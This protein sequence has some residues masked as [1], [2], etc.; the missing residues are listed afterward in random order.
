MTVENL[1]TK[2]ILLLP[3]IAS[4]VVS[5]ILVALTETAQISPAEYGQSPSGFAAAFVLALGGSL[6]VLWVLPLLMLAA[7]ALLIGRSHFPTRWPIIVPLGIAVMV[8]GVL[9]SYAKLV[10]YRPFAWYPPFMAFYAGVAI[11]L[12]A[13][14]ATF[15][16]SDRTAG[17]SRIVG[18]LARRVLPPL[19]LSIFAGLHVL[20]YQLYYDRYP[21]LHTSILMV[22]F[23]I[24]QAGLFSLFHLAPTIPRFKVPFRVALAV[25]S[26]LV[27]A[28]P[29]LCAIPSLNVFSPG[30]LRFTVVGQEISRNAWEA[31]NPGNKLGGGVRDPKGVEHFEKLSHMPPLPEDLDLLD[32]NILLV[33]IEAFRADESFMGSPARNLTP[34]LRAYAEEGAHWFPKAI[35]G[36]AYT[37]QSIASMFTM[38]YTSTTGLEL[39]NPRWDGY[40]SEKIPTVVDQLE[41]SGYD[42][43]WV[44]YAGGGSEDG[45]LDWCWPRFSDVAVHSRD[46]ELLKEVKDK[47]SKRKDNP[48]PFFGWVFFPAPHSPYEAHY[49]DMPAKTDKDRYRQELRYVD[50]V[51]NRLLS[52]IERIGIAEKTIVIIH[53]DHGEEFK[54]HGKTGH[55]ALYNECANVPLIIKIPGFKGGRVDE[56]VSLTYI[57]PWLLSRGDEDLRAVARSRME[58]V[59]GPVLEATDGAVVSEFFGNFGTRSL[60]AYP[61]YRFHHDFASKHSELYD[62]K[63]DPRE[64]KNIFDPDSEQSKTF[65]AL[66]ERY[67]EVRQKNLNITF[68]D[69]TLAEMETEGDRKARA[70]AIAKLKNSDERG[71]LEALRDKSDWRVQSAAITNLCRRKKLEDETVDELVRF[72]ADDNRELRKRVMKSSRGIDPDQFSERLLMA[73]RSDS[74]LR[75]LSYT[76]GTGKRRKM[77]HL[78]KGQ[79]KRIGKAALPAT[80][81]ALGSQDIAVLRY[82]TEAVGRFPREAGK[83]VERLEALTDH[84]DSKVRA[85]SEKSLAAI[86]GSI[87][88]RQ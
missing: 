65:L 5:L 11:L 35:T 75:G 42:T 32:Y 72:L 8:G 87:P 52:H 51:V 27:A 37:I 19:A 73:L 17:S 18:L 78:V 50:D 67:K 74:P 38:S 66:F 70:E 41:E 22:S 58:E 40:L 69:G 47:L 83:A 10:E 44:S 79:L 4:V 36:S 82:A 28:S 20:N 55:Q 30:F 85:N 86:V 57:F 21:A 81:D 59:F 3:F 6:E 12:A 29:L 80:I 54:D 14:F 53:G 56:L 84:P 34:H 39:H 26:L 9:L 68:T 24:L 31:D 2:M 45:I 88:H 60:L 16:V 61:G 43:F 25:L 15:P 48:D 1:K 71:L 62:M 46:E 77:D 23:L 63:R 76:L 64:K 33:S 49:D 7:T 13:W